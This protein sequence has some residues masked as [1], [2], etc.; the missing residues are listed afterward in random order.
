[1]A[2]ETT[3]Q[4]ELD[5]QQKQVAAFTGAVTEGMKD[6]KP[7]YND[8]GWKAGGAGL[9]WAGTAEGDTPDEAKLVDKDGTETIID[10]KIELGPMG[11][12]GN[13]TCSVEEG[14]ANYVKELASDTTNH[15]PDSKVGV[16]MWYLSEGIARDFGTTWSS[17]PSSLGGGTGRGGSKTAREKGKRVITKAEKNQLIERLDISFYDDDIKSGRLTLEEAFEEVK[18]NYEKKAAIEA[19]GYYLSPNKTEGVLLFDWKQI[20]NNSYESIPSIT[21]S[22]F[23]VYEKVEVVLP[24]IWE[25]Y[26]ADEHQKANKKTCQEVFKSIL[27]SFTI[28]DLMRFNLKG[29]APTGKSGGEF[30]GLVQDGELSTK[31]EILKVLKHKPIGEVKGIHLAK[32]KKPGLMKPRY[33][34]IDE[35]DAKGQVLYLYDQDGSC[36]TLKNY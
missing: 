26:F 36:T 14:V 8:P 5:E 20:I 21:A 27:G 6:G 28:N 35:Y 19:L 29:L 25:N 32:L 33:I 23:Y 24:N 9:Y 3:N 12:G 15:L 34:V 22:A 16:V 10:T 7:D 31:Q 2:P 13:L 17:A 18:K 30:G 4:Q 11:K 1:M